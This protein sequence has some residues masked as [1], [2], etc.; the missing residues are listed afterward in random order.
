MEANELLKPTKVML[1]LRKRRVVA[2]RKWKK[3]ERESAERP[4]KN[5][6]FV[7]SP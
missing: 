1:D 4:I 5:I 7:L 3:K 6:L 2:G